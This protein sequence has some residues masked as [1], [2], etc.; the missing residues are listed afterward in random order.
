LKKKQ[1]AIDEAVSAN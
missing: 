1:Q